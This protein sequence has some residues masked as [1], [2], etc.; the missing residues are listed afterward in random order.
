MRKSIIRAA[1]LLICMVNVSCAYARQDGL[2][3]EKSCLEQGWEKIVVNIAGN[4]RQFFWKSPSDT[5]GAW[6]KGAII[7]MHG[8]GGHYYQWCGSG[9]RLTAAQAR[10]SKM[11]V[12]Q[13]FAVF[14]LDSSDYVTDNEGRV[15]GK[16][17]DDEVRDRGNIDLP[18]IGKIIQN[19]IPSL[20]PQDGNRSIFLAGHSSGGYMTVRAA[21][22]FNNLVT[23]FAPVSSGDP[24]GWRRI[25]K[26]GLTMRKTVHG[27]GFDNE[28]G[29]QIIEKDACLASEYPHEKRWSDGGARIKPVF[30][31]FHHKFDGINNPSC[32]EKI[33]KQL[34]AHGYRQISAYWLDDNSHP[35]LRNH[36]WQDEYNQPLLDFFSMAGLPKF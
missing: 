12:E 17:W 18:F 35:S 27:A 28:T 25:C 21:T 2:R 20:R 19:I 11:A 5:N 33:D 24:Y 3:A 10:F 8:G 7:I 14:L 29:K 4:N 32:A 13:G 23:A 22:Y 6:P 31:V 9:G 1:L 16:I 15:C 30:R 34:L 26:K 36:L